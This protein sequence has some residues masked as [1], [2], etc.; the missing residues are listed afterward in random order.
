MLK[1]ID[2]QIIGLGLALALGFLVGLE[3]ERAPGKL[4]GLRSFALIGLTGGLAGLVADSWGGW[5]IAVGLATTAVVVVTH[6]ILHRTVAG[7]D[8]QDHGTTTALAA[9]AVFLIGVA[10]TSGHQA[11]AVVSGGVITILLHWKQPLHSLAGRMGHDEFGAMIRF[12]LITLVVLPVLPNQTFGPYDVFNPFHTWL[13]VVLIVGLNLA[14]YI[15]FRLLRADSGA[16]VGGLL[17][18]LISSTA[19]TVSFSGMTRRNRE[20]SASAALVI[21]IASTVVYARIGIELLVLAPTLLP[22]AAAPL[23]AFALVMLLLSLVLW[24]RVRR[25]QVTLPP[26]EN[27]ARLRVALTFAALYAVIIVSM[28][29]A[30]QHL[31]DDAIYGVAFVSGLTDVDALTVSMAQLFTGGRVSADLAWRSIFLASLSNLLFKIGAAS[32]LGAP[33]LRTYLVS[34]GGAALGVGIAMLLLWP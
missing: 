12:V 6:L 34:L 22:S 9:L 21:L 16:V 33:Q 13:L 17:G 29:A 4:V 26:Q 11:P 18:G 7:R 19:T 20:L 2:P 3:R 1:F 10:C 5:V 14:G 25:R 31:G 15:A 32:L 30:R 27:P 23:G 24:P 8:D 28:A